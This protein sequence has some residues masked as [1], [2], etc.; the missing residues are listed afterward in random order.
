MGSARNGRLFPHFNLLAT[1]S[2]GAGVILLQG[3]SPD[4]AHT[5]TGAR[6]PAERHHLRAAYFN[7][8]LQ[9]MAA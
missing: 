7:I 9:L 2:H 8:S 6:P 4:P 1:N 3:C 5:I